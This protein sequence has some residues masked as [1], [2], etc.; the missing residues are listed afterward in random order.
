MVT[1][2]SRVNASLSSSTTRGLTGCAGDL[3]VGVVDVSMAERRM[4]AGT[5][6]QS[7]A[8]ALGRRPSA[9]QHLSHRAR[10]VDNTGGN[11]SIANDSAMAENHEQDP[12]PLA[13]SPL[14][15]C[16]N[17][18]VSHVVLADRGSSRSSERSLLKSNRRALS[19]RSCRVQVSQLVAVG[20]RACWTGGSRRLSCEGGSVRYVALP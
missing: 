17:P 11:V 14:R 2:N 19:T 18:A 7:T 3:Q 6:R 12:N 16:S 9:A 8:T 20:A 13:D 5:D 15:S 4:R 10:A 1:V